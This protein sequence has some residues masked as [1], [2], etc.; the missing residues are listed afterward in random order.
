MSVLRRLSIGLAL[1][2]GLALFPTA[3]KAQF[4]HIFNTTGGAVAGNSITLAQ[5][6]SGY[7]IDINNGFDTK[8]FTGRD[9]FF[10]TPTGSSTAVNP[11]QVTV[12]GDSSGGLDPG[13][14]LVFQ[15]NFTALNGTLDTRFDY[16]V[17]VLPPS[18]FLIHDIRLDAAGF[19]DTGGQIRITETATGTDVNG[20]PIDAV[21][22]NQGGAP[23][24]FQNTTDIA[25]FAG[26]TSLNIHKDIFLQSGSN[27]GTT[28][29]DF[30]QRFSQTA[31]PEPS[32]MALAGLGALGLIGYGLRRR[33]AL[34][35]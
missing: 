21:M 30:D 31:I 26:V 32:T 13:P 28:I 27:V 14:Q 29:T 15:G 2:V 33:K 19:I 4:V 12:T 6:L 23:G 24:T 17:T 20:T 10:S 18:G 3:A 9:S 34:G 11:N 8:E 5:F 35:A 16:N 1:L 7:R 22:T 25:F